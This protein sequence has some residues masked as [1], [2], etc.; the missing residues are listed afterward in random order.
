MSVK[1]ARELERETVG[2]DETFKKKKADVEKVIWR[3]YAVPPIWITSSSPL[4]GSSSQTL[5]ES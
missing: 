2:G 3:R 1:G 4:F 5:F